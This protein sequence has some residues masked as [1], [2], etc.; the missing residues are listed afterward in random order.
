MRPRVIASAAAVVAV[1]GAFGIGFWA[2]SQQAMHL[3]IYTADGHVGA[4]VATLMVGDVAYG[5]RSTVDWTDG[6]GVE[7]AGGWPECL[8]P[9]EATNVRFAGA[10]LWHE[11]IGIATITWVDCRDR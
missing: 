7:H 8:P 4:N 2:G 5:V 6:N 11:N 1:I 9:G 3:P 10:V